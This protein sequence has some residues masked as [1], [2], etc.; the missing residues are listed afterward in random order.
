MNVAE[1]LE[2]LSRDLNSHVVVSADCL[3]AAGR[4]T[5]RGPWQML[6]SQRLPGREQMLDVYYLRGD[7]PNRSAGSER[8]SVREPR[9]LVKV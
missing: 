6:S 4:A 7:D 8:K 3:N 1:R 9:E 5:D 2:R